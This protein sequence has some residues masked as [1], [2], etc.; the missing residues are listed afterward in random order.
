MPVTPELKL[1]TRENCELCDQFA[2]QMRAA[3]PVV[4]F[5]V[6]DVDSNPRWQRRYGNDIPVL[7]ADDTAICMHFFDIEK[8][9]ENLGGL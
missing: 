3:L 5:E 8:V 7:L 9:S 1:L 6:C 2:N 4:N